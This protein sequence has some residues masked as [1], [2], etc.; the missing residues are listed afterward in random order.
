MSDSTLVVQANDTL[1][2]VSYT[3]ITKSSFLLPPATAVLGSGPQGNLVA[4]S[5]RQT[6]LNASGSVTQNR[7]EIIVF[8]R[9]GTT[10]ASFPN[11][12]YSATGNTINYYATTGS[13]IDAAGRIV[14]SNNVGAVQVVGK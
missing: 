10:L 11:N 5:Q 1:K 13:T 4:N 14:A 7:D 8:S 6:I 3:H 2:F 9:S 12:Y